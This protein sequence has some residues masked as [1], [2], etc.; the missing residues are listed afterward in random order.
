MK[1]A[2]NTRYGAPD[3]VQ[4]RDVP[5]PEPNAN[6]VLIRVCA[7][8]VSRTDC[9]M[10]RPKPFFVRLFA[11]LTRPK[12]TILGMDF[13][14]T[15]ENVGSSVTSYKRGDRVFGLSPITYGGHAEYL[16][17]PEMRQWSPSQRAS[18]SMKRSSAKAHGML[19]APC[20]N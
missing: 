17:L 16:C 11:G 1:A 7:T 5:K 2:V 6:E 3:V 9:G 14:G 8:T 12:R 20:E 10:R 18:T 13:A 15:V 19:T 4:I